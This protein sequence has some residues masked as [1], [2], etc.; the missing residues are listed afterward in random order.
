[1]LDILEDIDMCT[2]ESVDITKN[3]M[4]S[5]VDSVGE[6]TNV[7]DGKAKLEDVLYSIGN[8]T[9]NMFE[10]ADTWA[11]LP[12]RALGRIIS[13]T[14]KACKKAS[15]SS[16]NN[17]KAKAI[18]RILE[19]T[20]SAVVAFTETESSVHAATAAFRNQLN[21]VDPTVDPT[22]DPPPDTS[23]N[24]ETPAFIE[25]KMDVLKTADALAPQLGMLAAPDALARHNLETL[26]AL[27][28]VKVR[29]YARENYPG[30]K[31][32][33]RALKELREAFDS[34]TVSL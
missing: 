1:M 33:E 22:V 2:T 10:V 5:L 21:S 18:V 28:G 23:P 13:S 34:C 27:W 16:V 19:A 20:A 30:D 29:D 25:M 8:S 24:E 31:T 11:N 9:A 14:V 32:L 7:L 6:L 26:A 17:P 15:D 4:N 3:A 12:S